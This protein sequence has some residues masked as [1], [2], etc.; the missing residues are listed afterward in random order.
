[1]NAERQL[2]AKIVAGETDLFGQL[3]EPC[4]KIAKR[5]LAQY[6]RSIE[7]ED[8]IQQAA[9]KALVNLPR[10][11]GECRF[12]S[13]FYRIALNEVIYTIRDS[14]RRDFVHI[15]A[16]IDDNGFNDF[17][18]AFLV[19]SRE[20]PEES[21]ERRERCAFIVRAIRKMNKKDRQ[22]LIVRELNGGSVD[23]HARI[24]GVSQGTCKTR[25][26]RARKNLRIRYEQE[27]D[28][29]SI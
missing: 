4:L 6:G 2:I 25:I 19:D 1:M 24:A 26:V 8:C 23:D 18:P 15:E 5:A 11:K 12:S 16:C 10:F 14:K 28:H 22:S 29:V 27:I 7:V 21:L 9:L 3:V 17:T 13:W 20:N